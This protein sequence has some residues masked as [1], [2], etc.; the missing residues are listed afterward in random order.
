MGNQS[1]IF[2]IRK[3]RF[4]EALALLWKEVVEQILPKCFGFMNNQVPHMQWG[5]CTFGTI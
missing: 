2:Q 5:R 1:L 3:P 4:R